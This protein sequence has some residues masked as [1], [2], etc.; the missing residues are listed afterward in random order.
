[1]AYNKTEWQNGDVI[2]AEKLNNMENGIE[3][4]F[5]SEKLIK[6]GIEITYGA[7]NK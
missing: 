2:T 4:T 5:S 3:E 7:E 6:I 1:M